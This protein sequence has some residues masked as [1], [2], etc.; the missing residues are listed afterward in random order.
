MILRSDTY[1]NASKPNSK[2]TSLTSCWLHALIDSIMQQCYFVPP[3]DLQFGY[4]QIHIASEDMPE[5]AF[6]DFITR[7]PETDIVS[8]GSD[9]LSRT[10]HHDG[11]CEIVLDSVAICAARL[12]EHCFQ[13]G[14]CAEAIALSRWTP[15]DV[16]RHINTSW[17][18]YYSIH[19]SSI[20]CSRLAMLASLQLDQVLLGRSSSRVITV[21]ALLM[22]AMV[23][24][25]D[26]KPA[27][28][29]TSVITYQERH[30]VRWCPINAHTEK[31]QIQADNLLAELYIGPN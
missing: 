1:G 5:T 26:C 22:N 27:S 3:V 6:L 7:L 21:T 30:C 12:H 19:A 16:C 25:H 31:L 24:L 20:P 23:L 8:I 29:A 14:A 17:L 2:V 9:L 10:V 4:H 28:G 13:S 18:L 15:V 11:W